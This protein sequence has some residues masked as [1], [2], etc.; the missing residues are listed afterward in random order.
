MRFEHNLAYASHRHPVGG[1]SRRFD[2]VLA[3][4]DVVDGRVLVEEH[5]LNV[6]LGNGDERRDDRDPRAPEVCQAK[7]GMPLVLVLKPMFF[8]KICTALTYP[9][10]FYM[11]NTCL[12]RHLPRDHR[13][14]AADEV[15]GEPSEDE[16]VTRGRSLRGEEFCP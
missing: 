4:D 7:N 16:L 9:W 2:D 3:P 6:L 8:D 10:R 14:V 13:V 5:V 11:K 15:L 1:L 12:E